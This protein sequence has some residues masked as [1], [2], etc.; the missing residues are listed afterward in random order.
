MAASTLSRNT[1]MPRRQV[2]STVPLPYGQGDGVGDGLGRAG[3]GEAPR[4]RTPP[5]PETPLTVDGVEVR[6]EAPEQAQ[7]RAAATPASAATVR[8]GERMEPPVSRDERYRVPPLRAAIK[9]G[10]GAGA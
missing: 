10:C 7:A 2:V 8:E 6:G 5:G 4:P 9:P 3:L 1:G